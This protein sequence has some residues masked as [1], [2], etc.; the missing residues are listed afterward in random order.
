M[1]PFDEFEFKPLTEGLGFHNKAT[2]LKDQVA[3]SGLTNELLQSLPTSMPSEG[4]SSR[5]AITFDDVIGSLEKAPLK[6]NPSSL[7]NKSFLEVTEPLP[8]MRSS[9]AFKTSEL[10]VPRGPVQSPFP[11]SDIFRQPQPPSSNKQVP[12]AFKQSS[13]LNIQKK[14]SSNIGTRRGAADS[15]IGKLVL[16]SVSVPSAILDFVVVTA[17]TLIFVSAMLSVTKVDIGILM[18][19]TDSDLLTRI[20]LG[21]LFLAIMQMYAVISRSFYGRTLGEWTF[22]VQLGLKEDQADTFYPMKVIFRS[23]LVSLTGVII[24]PLLSLLLRT[25]LAGRISGVRL[26]RQQA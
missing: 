8:R 26:Y 5:K 23:M 1:D 14:P 3:K 9:D 7:S 12:S 10:E 19:S 11:S 18:N 15:P 25:D 4:T 17:L 22:D 20:S 6:Q 13:Q 21:L 24:L 2:S 16:A